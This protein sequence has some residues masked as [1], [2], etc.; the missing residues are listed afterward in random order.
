MGAAA[1][2]G[3]AEQGLPFSCLIADSS[4]DRLDKQ[5]A[6]VFKEQTGLPLVPFFPVSR[7]FYHRLVGIAMHDVD[8][9]SWAKNLK[10]PILFVHSLS[11]AFTPSSCSQKLFDKTSSV[12]KQVWFP[13]NTEHAETMNQNFPDYQH[14]IQDFIRL[15]PASL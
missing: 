7:W 11:D 4:F 9:V 3:A 10:I 2:I 8:V 15:L 12:N 5:I 13:E 6:R 1:L 14:H